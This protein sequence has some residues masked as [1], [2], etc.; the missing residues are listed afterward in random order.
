MKTVD[1]VLYEG[2]WL[3]NQ[4][5][6]TGLFT[7]EVSSFTALESFQLEGVWS[8]RVVSYTVGTMVDVP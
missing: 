2:D 1:G 5:M 6:K 8:M 3:N 4:V 7:A